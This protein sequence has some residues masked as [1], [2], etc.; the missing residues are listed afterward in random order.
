MKKKEPVNSIVHNS[1]V[2]F[3]KESSNK[4]HGS[5][6]HRKEGP[7]MEAKLT[8]TRN[9]AISLIQLIVKFSLW[10]TAESWPWKIITPSRVRKM[11]SE[12]TMRFYGHITSI[13]IRTC[14]KATKR[15]L[16]SII[17]TMLLM[18]SGFR[19][20]KYLSVCLSTINI[21]WDQQ[22]LKKY[23]RMNWSTS[24]RHDLN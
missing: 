17:F 16:K 13:Y 1:I 14:S 6:T 4:S 20:T 2:N 22:V 5:K 7:F 3:P 10:R 24:L 15:Q 9:D 19:P 12:K 11:L 21:N 18:S 8:W 23:L